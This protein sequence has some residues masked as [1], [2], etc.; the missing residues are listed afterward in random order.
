MGVIREAAKAAVP[1]CAFISVHDYNLPGRTNSRWG[2]MLKQAGRAAVVADISCRMSEPAQHV[3]QTSQSSQCF[4]GSCGWQAT[5]EETD[6]LCFGHRQIKHSVS[7]PLSLLPD[8][9]MSGRM[10]SC[11]DASSTANTSLAHS[12][13]CVSQPLLSHCHADDAYRLT[14]SHTCT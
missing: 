2:C 9:L 1:R 3:L 14:A 7:S 6:W 10:T 13:A 12:D 8:L 4:S 11:W 5:A